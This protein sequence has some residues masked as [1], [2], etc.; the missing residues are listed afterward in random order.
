MYSKAGQAKM[1]INLR[2]RLKVGL[3]GATGMVGRR[4]AQLLIDHPWFEPV[5]FVGSEASIGK[6]YRLVWE[7]KEKLLQDHYG[8]QLWK[9]QQFPRALDGITIA[10]FQDLFDSEIEIVFSSLPERAGCFEAALLDSGRTVFSNSPYRRFDDSAALVVA[11]VNGTEMSDRHLIK[12]PN[13]VTSGLAL[14][15][16]PIASRYGLDTV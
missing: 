6:S 2:S 13:C 12:N 10:G 8:A 14:V 1:P 16:A 15:L 9:L 4:M 11:E 5:I 3:L 7:Y